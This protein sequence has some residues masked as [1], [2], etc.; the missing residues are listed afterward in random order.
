MGDGQHYLIVGEYNVDDMFKIEHPNL[1]PSVMNRASGYGYHA[2]DCYV[3][4]HESTFH[5]D[6]FFTHID[7]PTS[8]PNERVGPGRHAIETWEERHYTHQGAAY[9]IKSGLRL[10]TSTRAA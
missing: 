7:D 1:C 5:L 6:K 2:H 4:W 10:V 8:D 3:G 9:Q